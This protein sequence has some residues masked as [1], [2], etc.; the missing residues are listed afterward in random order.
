MNCWRKHFP[1][2]DWGGEHIIKEEYVMK[3]KNLLE[4]LEFGVRQQ[5]GIMSVIPLLGAD[6]TDKLATFEDIRFKG[7]T[8]YGTMVF[9]N[10]SDKPFIIPTGYSIITKQLAQDHALTFASML[11]PQ[12]TQSYYNACCIQQTQG[13]Y[14]DG[15]SLKEEFSIL[16]LYVR[17]Q[18]F[19]EYI[20][21]QQRGDKQYLSFAKDDFSRLWPIISDFQSKL[22][23][24][25]EGNIVLFFN[26]FV[27]QLNKFNA[28]FEV[29]HG[30]RGAIILLN[31]KIVGIEVAPTQE[32]W[33]TVW[34]SLIRDCYGAEVIRRTTL[35]LVEEFE[36]SQDSELNLDECLT[37]E[38]I[39]KELKRHNKEAV[40]RAE[41]LVKGLL[42]NNIETL[43]FNHEL[44]SQNSYGDFKY[45]LFK[46]KGEAIYGEVY[47]DKDD[48]IY[49][50]ILA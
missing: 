10:N 17:K 21:P 23:Q 33:K 8:S 19:Q 6:V 2:L 44:V 12:S 24:R 13:G 14:I 37:I 18:H 28:E 27:D 1:P 7:T 30:Q 20:K 32:Y 40:E 3:L 22:I 50:S 36:K 15:D 25:S 34:N 43:S 35:N 48:I 47:T 38:D 45:F 46:A 26:K 11:K 29:V 42:K 41:E 49:A 31:D 4:G 5:A 9:R 39:E 16:P